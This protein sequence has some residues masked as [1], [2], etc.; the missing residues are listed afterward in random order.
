MDSDADPISTSAPRA[1]ELEEYPYGPQPAVIDVRHYDH[2]RELKLSKRFFAKGSGPYYAVVC[3]GLF[4]VGVNLAVCPLMAVIHGPGWK[5]W[6]V[7][8]L[9]GAV[10]AEAGILSAALVFFKGPFWLRAASCWSVG[11]LLWASWMLGLLFAKR[12]ASWW[13]IGDELQFGTLSL[14]LVVLAIQSPLWFARCYS[15]WR[16]T[17]HRL[18]TTASASLSIRD[19]FVG[20]AITAISITLARL[21]R[22]VHWPIDDY[23]PVW[24]LAFASFAVGSL[25]SIIPGMLFLFLLRN[26]W[27]GLGLFLLYSLALSTAIV[28][29][30]H[31]ASQGSLSVDEVPGIAIMFFSVGLFL[32]ISFVLA[33]A[34]GCTLQLSRT[35]Q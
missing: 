33:R 12:I 31:F 32:A 13:K 17:H 27:L 28:A 3:F 18:S 5:T 11:V 24:G 19:Y 7:F 16:L 8:G 23:W 22:P 9:F 21:A 25:F 26:T 2:D 4:L 30:I 20:T 35:S 10:V 34:C 14:P 1:S 29:I 6:P 15:K